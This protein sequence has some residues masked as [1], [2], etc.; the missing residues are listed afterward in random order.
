MQLS[1]MS[2]DK[3]KI[4]KLRSLELFVGAGGLA[5]GTARAGFEHVAVVDLHNPSCE[6]LRYNKRNNV[7][8][9]RDWEI[10]ETDIS[11]LAFFN[12]RGH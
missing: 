2:K 4:L 1:E 6:T 12:L 9:V 5:L 11:A 7:A 3:G 8:H 10:L